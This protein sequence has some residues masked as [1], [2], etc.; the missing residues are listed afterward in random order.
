MQVADFNEEQMRNSIRL[1][2]S[3]EIMRQYWLRASIS[4]SVAQIPGT[5]PWRMAR[6]GNEIYREYE[7]DA[8]FADDPPEN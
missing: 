7:P 6:L 5:Y 1:V 8:V 4:R 2:F 3:N